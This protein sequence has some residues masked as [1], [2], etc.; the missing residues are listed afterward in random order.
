[1][2]RQD[3]AYEGFEG[4]ILEEWSDFLGAVFYELSED[5]EVTMGRP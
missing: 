5:E 1:M 2:E 3:S 4:T